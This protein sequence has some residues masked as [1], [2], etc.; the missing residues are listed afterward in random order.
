MPLHLRQLAERLRSQ[1]RSRRSAKPAVLH[2]SGS[3]ET[4]DV[5]ERW[6]ELRAEM[7]VKR[8]R[9]EAGEE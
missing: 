2:L 6:A 8:E 5:E 7:R 4:G 1:M 9:M 3:E